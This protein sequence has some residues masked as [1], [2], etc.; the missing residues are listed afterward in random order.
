MCLLI[1]GCEDDLDEP[2]TNVVPDIEQNENDN[3]INNNVN[4]NIVLKYDDFVITTDSLNFRDGPSTDTA[5]KKTFYK[6]EE[7]EVINRSADDEWLYVKNNGTYGYVSAE[8][9]ISAFDKL[10]EA[11]P[12]TTLKSIDVKKIVFATDNLNI[13][14]MPGTEYDIVETISKYVTVR[15]LDEVDDW[16]FVMTNEYKFGYVSKQYTEE[17][18]GS[19]VIVD[20]S[21]QRLYL[22]SNSE[23]TVSTV[24][25]TGKN[26]TPSDTGKFQI[27]SKQT[28]RYLTG[29]DYRSWVDY[30]MPYN[31]GEGLHDANWHNIFGTDSYQLYG[32]HGCINIPP[33]IAGLVYN[34]VYVGTTVIVHQ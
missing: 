9:T 5:V 15:V 11:Y 34:N 8:Y 6:N 27:Y 29:P 7:L 10:K 2:E 30:W 22:Y 31:G 18:S 23:L 4:E 12:N 19:F 3:N 14:S 28:A 33:S 13:R 32:S 20:K 25:T 16:Y 17:L 24:V 21:V 26:S 1:C